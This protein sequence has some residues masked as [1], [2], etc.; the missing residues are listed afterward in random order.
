MKECASASTGSEEGEYGDLKNR[1][2]LR[3]DTGIVRLHI[4][5]NLGTELDTC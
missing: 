5:E 4:A 2:K 1:R 3:G